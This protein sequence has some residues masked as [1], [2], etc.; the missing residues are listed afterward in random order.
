MSRVGSSRWLG[1]SQSFL[2][3]GTVK[4]PKVGDLASLASLAGLTHRWAQACA[5]A[6]PQRPPRGGRGPDG[7]QGPGPAWQCGMK[8]WT[9]W[10]H[11]LSLLKL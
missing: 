7:P 11:S 1:A 5:A 9:V 3:V 6:A 10:I 2:L 4:E 8:I